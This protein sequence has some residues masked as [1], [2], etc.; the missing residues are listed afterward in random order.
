MTLML[1]MSFSDSVTHSNRILAITIS[2]IIP[3]AYQ[4]PYS[5]LLLRVGHCSPR[6][7]VVMLLIRLSEH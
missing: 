3:V 2:E 5:G 6:R 7:S 1:Y 4:I